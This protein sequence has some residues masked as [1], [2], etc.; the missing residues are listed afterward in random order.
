MSNFFVII[1]DR[2]DNTQRT[3]IQHLVKDNA[4]SW[5]HD[6][7]DV[8]VVEGGATSVFWRDLLRPIVPVAPC[9]LLVLAL[10]KDGARG[11]AA[12]IPNIQDRGLYFRDKYASTPQTLTKD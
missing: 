1:G 4:E 5:W 3:Q 7:L 12:R 10:P 9:G 6:F 11:W 8:W 2:I